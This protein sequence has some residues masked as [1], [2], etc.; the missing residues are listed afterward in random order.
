MNIQTAKSNQSK[1]YYQCVTCLDTFIC[2]DWKLDEKKTHS[3][4]ICPY[5]KS[6]SINAQNDTLPLMMH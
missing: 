2:P 3:I 1:Y 6:Y 4:A 5:C